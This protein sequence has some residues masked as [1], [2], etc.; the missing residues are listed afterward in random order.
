MELADHVIGVCS[1]SLKCRD[2]PQT[3]AAVKNLG[4]SHMQLALGGLMEA[5][6]P[7][8]DDT[9][10]LLE[11]E[12]IQLTAGMVGFAGEDYTT[13]ATIKAERRPVA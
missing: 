6:V 11:K 10:K 8:I 13:I 7:A 3:I 12:Q 2:I 9:I 4:L 1:W 5:G